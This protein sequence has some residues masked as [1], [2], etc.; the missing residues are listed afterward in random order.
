MHD[1]STPISDEAV[2][3]A[4][5]A[6]FRYESKTLPQFRTLDAYARAALEAAAPFMLGST[7]TRE[8]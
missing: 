2:E 3:A 4:A 6:M 7:E 5:V 1:P 8:P